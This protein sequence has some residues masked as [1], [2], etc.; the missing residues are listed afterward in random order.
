[1]LPHVDSC[2]ILT[3]F[4]GSHLLM[5][6]RISLTECFFGVNDRPS[7][8]IMM[9]RG[10]TVYCNS[11]IMRLRVIIIIWQSC[12]SALIAVVLKH[13]QTKNPQ[14]WYM[15]YY[16]VGTHLKRFNAIVRGYF[17]GEIIV[18]LDYSSSSATQF[19]VGYMHFENHCFIVLGRSTKMSMCM[20]ELCALLRSLVRED[21]FPPCLNPHRVTVI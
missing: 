13:L 17:M 15:T 18:K 16:T 9:N 4:V 1:M 21:C 8:E 19:L 5:C 7:N 3:Q 20:T 2:L 14:T 10:C 12:M 6:L 11:C